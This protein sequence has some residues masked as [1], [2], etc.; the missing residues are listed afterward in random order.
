[1]A[2]ATM[3]VFSGSNAL[4]LPSAGLCACAF[5]DHVF[6]LPPTTNLATMPVVFTCPLIPATIPKSFLMMRMAKF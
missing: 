1:M 3:L 6:G 5:D 2:L 4:L